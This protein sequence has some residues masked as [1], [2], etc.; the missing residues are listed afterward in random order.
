[1]WA[2]AW[3]SLIGAWDSEWLQN[4]LNVIIVLFRRYN[5][6]A[7]VVNFLTMTC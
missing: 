4:T 2:H 3:D 6:V 1:M 5:P 7:N